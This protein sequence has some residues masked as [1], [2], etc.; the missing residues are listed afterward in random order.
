VD[1]GSCK[2]HSNDGRRVVGVWSSEVGLAQR[3]ATVT[4]LWAWQRLATSQ[5][6]GNL[7]YRCAASCNVIKVGVCLEVKKGA[8]MIQ[9][10]ETGTNIWQL[11]HVLSVK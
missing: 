2:R 9:V 5:Q 4:R 3:H 1:C 11:S 7:L 6:L 8:S 10:Q